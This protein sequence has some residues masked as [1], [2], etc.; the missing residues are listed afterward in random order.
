[1]RLSIL[2]NAR[3]TGT[4]RTLL[5]REPRVWSDPAMSSRVVGKKQI[6]LENSR[7][8]RL[9]LRR[10][11]APNPCAYLNAAACTPPPPYNDNPGHDSRT[12]RSG[13]VGIDRQQLN[14]TP[15]FL[16]ALHCPVL[17]PERARSR[18]EE[19]RQ[20]DGGVPG[21]P[22]LWYLRIAG[23]PPGSSIRQDVDALQ[24]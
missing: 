6:H 15:T 1:M 11:Q 24:Q 13:P 3:H 10:L 9:L 2:S 21:R 12:S 23:H 14:A 5:R 22:F 7:T 16:L 8:P 20:E 19:R 18:G 17:S 4:S